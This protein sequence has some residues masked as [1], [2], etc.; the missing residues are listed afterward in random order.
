MCGS[1]GIEGPCF[2]CIHCE[3]FSIC[4]MCEPRVS[5]FHSADHVFEIMYESNY[6]WS[7]VSLPVDM[8]VRIVRHQGTMPPV[9][10]E[11]VIGRITAYPPLIRGSVKHRMAVM[12]GQQSPAGDYD[13]IV[14]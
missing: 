11:G 9:E 3:S 5:A 6:D 2:R 10:S 14:T 13:I 1:R 4:S 8:P 7:Q 12:L